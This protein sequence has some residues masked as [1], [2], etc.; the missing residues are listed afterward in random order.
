M[1]AT[2]TYPVIE[3]DRRHTEYGSELEIELPMPQRDVAIV[4]DQVAPTLEMAMYANGCKENTAS[5]TYTHLSP[6]HA[7]GSAITHSMLG[8]PFGLVRHRAEMTDGIWGRSVRN[9][10]VRLFNHFMSDCA[11]IVVATD[12]SGMP[13]YRLRVAHSR[14]DLPHAETQRLDEQATVEIL[15]D[16]IMQASIGKDDAIRP[17]SVE[18][19]IDR[20]TELSP[21]VRTIRT[22]KYQS[23]RGSY[24]GAVVRVAE[25]ST[26]V[27][28]KQPVNS[29]EIELLC[30]QP[31]DG[32][33][34]SSASTG[35]T[36]ATQDQIPVL[37]A[38]MRSSFHLVPGQRIRESVRDRLL[39]MQIE[40]YTNPDDALRILALHVNRLG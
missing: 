40:R 3:L 26:V 25:E 24:G 8:Q 18:E 9:A 31:V 17:A 13:D 38:R 20:F 11:E 1:L 39:D 5:G 21:A 37:T 4:N 15:G 32:I 2:D 16:L 34:V 19:A 12:E 35:L 27:H 10:H 33:K 22:G 36:V 29:L 14:D 7:P 23:M 30:Q 6:L 28:G